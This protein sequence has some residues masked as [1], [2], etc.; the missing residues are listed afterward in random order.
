MSSNAQSSRPHHRGA[1]AL[2]AAVVAVL[3]V[4]ATAGSAIAGATGAPV[5]DPERSAV[6]PTGWHFWI[7]Q[8]KADV[9]KLAQDS[10]E[11]VVNV[12]VVSAEPLRV[13]A[14]LVKNDGPYRRPEV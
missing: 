8:S 5:Q 12:Q 3:A 11:R 4:A 10:G 6:T 14:V 1:L 2:V 7:G 9:D 13:R